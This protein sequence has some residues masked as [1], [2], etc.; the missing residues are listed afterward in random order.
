MFSSF[1]HTVKMPPKKRAAAKSTATAGQKKQKLTQKADEELKAKV[2]ELKKDSGKK[3]TF[4]VDS[5]VTLPSVS[6]SYLSD[7]L[8]LHCDNY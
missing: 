2:E 7:K 6:V 5:Y 4:Q 3:S 8:H 1:H